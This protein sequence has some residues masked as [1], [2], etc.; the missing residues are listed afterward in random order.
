[1]RPTAEL[2]MELCS[3]IKPSNAVAAD[4]MD[5]W[6]LGASFCLVAERFRRAYRI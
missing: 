2:P 5:A 3:D 1:M 6:L 4:G